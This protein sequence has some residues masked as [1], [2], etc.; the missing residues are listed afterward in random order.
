[1]TYPAIPRLWRSSWEQLLPFL[2]Y[3][4]AAKTCGR[5]SGRWR[6]RCPATVSGVGMGGAERL[7]TPV[8]AASA[9]C[10][11]E[12]RPPSP[13]SPLGSTPVR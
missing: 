2:D 10:A 9:A 5:A 6:L 11:R 8:R 4:W 3:A 13:G 12:Y 1:M 7:P